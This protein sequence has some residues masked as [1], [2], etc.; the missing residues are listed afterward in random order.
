L[1]KRLCIHYNPETSGCDLYRALLPARHLRR[2]FREQGVPIEVIPVDKLLDE[3]VFDGVMI[4]RVLSDPFT[5]HIAALAA[6][7]IAV[8]HDTDDLLPDMPAWNPVRQAWK[9]ADKDRWDVLTTC[10]TVS[11]ASTKPLAERVRPDTKV[12]P[13]MIDLADWR[14]MR[15]HPDETEKIRILWA[16]SDTHHGDLELIVE[17]LRRIMDEFGDKVQVVFLGYSHP[18][19]KASHLMRYAELPMVPLGSYV[20]TMT[21]IHPHIAI[22]PLQKHPFNH[23]KSEIRYLETTASG[24]AFIYS[25]GVATYEGSVGIAADG[26]DEWYEAIKE[27]VHNHGERKR[28]HREAIKDVAANWTWQHAAAKTA[29]WTEAI[30]QAMGV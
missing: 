29:M 23:S 3:D 9:A 7:G 8:I 25:K 1:T 28:L 21:R 4:H 2:L 18:E 30:R 12:C 16:G 27:L 26:D 24:G 19:L 14:G 5:R 17:P 20:Q 13:N 15:N 11:I 6:R 22:G 10:A